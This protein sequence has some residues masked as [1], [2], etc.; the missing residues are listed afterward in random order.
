M[1]PIWYLMFGIGV[2]GANS[3]LLSPIA[4]AV[5][6]SFTDT[7][8]PEVMLAASVYGA[9]TALSALFLAPQADRIGLRRALL[10]AFAGLALALGISAVAPSLP[11]LVAAQALAGLAGGLALPA[12]YGLAAEIAPKGQES[13]TLGKVLTG[14]TL[15][16]V[17]G[18]SL[19]AIVADFAHWRW[20]YGGLTM[21][22]LA[23]L[24]GL[25]RAPLTDQAVPGVAASPVRALGIKGLKPRLLGVACFMMA[26]YG[27]YAFLGT[28]LTRD[29]GLSTALAGVA[30]LSYGIGF[31]AVAPLDRL[32]DRAG[33]ARAAP[34]VFALLIGAYGV[35][36]AVAASGALVLLACALWGA[37]NHLGLNLL[38]G[39]LTALAPARRATILGLYSATTY[40][41]MFAGTALFKLV[42][43]AVGF[44]GAAL[45]AAALIGPVLVGTM[46]NRRTAVL[47]ATQDQHP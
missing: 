6:K 38:V 42:F 8:G 37:V 7:T 14:W 12:I 17:V 36:S 2:V 29:L 11:V 1:Q 13:A 46:L 26:F 10:W 32:I 21:V 16:L 28:H 19:S 5:A 45:V 31:G 43:E 34:V 25:A 22:A 23:L 47:P 24:G 15:S 40:I 4:G 35:L 18:V 44:A 41:A 9:G 3:L 39:A 20:V 30:A 27:L 33:P